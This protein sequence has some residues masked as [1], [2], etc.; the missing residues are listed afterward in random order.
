ME[1]NNNS[2]I[3]EHKEEKQK[4]EVKP[5]ESTKVESKPVVHKVKA[6]KI[7]KN[8]SKLLKKCSGLF[9]D[10]W[11]ISTAV[12]ALALIVLT[13]L[14]F[15]GN[16]VS[17]SLSVNEIEDKV[18]EFAKVQGLEI[19]AMNTTIDSG[20]YSVVV[21]IEGQE[22]APIYLTLDG[23]YLVYGSLVKYT[24]II[25]EYSNSSSEESQLVPTERPTIDLFVMTHCPYGTQAEKGFIP[26]MKNMNKYADINIRYVHYF[27]HNPEYNETPRQIC[28]REEQNDKFL[29]YLECFLKGD[30]VVDSDG[31][32]TN[33]NN[34]ETCMKEANVDSKKVTECVT[35]KKWEEYY[36]ADSELSNKYGVQGSP[37]LVINGVQ[38]SYGRSPAAYLEGACTGFINA[39]NECSTLKLDTATPSVYFGW[40]T[41]TSTSS[42][43]C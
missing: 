4:E 35:S 17:N 16:S 30:G 32:I 42:G 40:S 38:A 21:T 41:T 6:Q 18:R 10:K 1:E 43:A 7:K 27:M 22:Y 24:Q 29:S 2:K 8:F 26:F 12:L 31:Y 9:K 20:V 37:T 11:A 25:A 15:T 13:I 36:A 14:S 5:I 34:P 19:D 23:E 33:G 39:P 28:I 3:E